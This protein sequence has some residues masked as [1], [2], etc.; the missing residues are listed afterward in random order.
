MHSII[1]RIFY[2]LLIGLVMVLPACSKRDALW[3]FEQLK[4]ENYQEVRYFYDKKNNSLAGEPDRFPMYPG[5][6]NAF[7][8]ALE[9]R[10][11]YTPADKRDRVQGEV[12]AKYVIN[13]E[14]RIRKVTIIKSLTPSLDRA[15]IKGLRTLRSRWFP[16]VINGNAVEITFIQTFDFKLE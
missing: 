5:G 12:I 14:G 2:G 7:L 10:I 9:R 1:S 16:A 13:R 3:S 6:H 15:V 11:M 4:E 8:D